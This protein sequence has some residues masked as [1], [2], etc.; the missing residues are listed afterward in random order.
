MIHTD[1]HSGMVF[2][3]YINKWYELSLN[4][5]KFLLILLVCIFQV[6]E[7]ASRIHIVTRIDA[8]L[9]AI[10]SRDI[11]G[12]SRKMH[13]SNKRCVVAVGLQLCRDIFHILCLTRALCGKTNQFTTSIN[14]TLSLCYT[15][16]GIVGICSGHRLDTDGIVTTN[17]DIAHMGYTAN[18]S[19]SHT[20]TPIS[21]CLPSQS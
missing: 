17:S 10:L 12:V 18:S 13:V 5:L 20:S 16:L 7:G 14:D 2:L 3:T 19:C 1:A 9:L 4:L 11:S 6:L 15:G 8:Y 21:P